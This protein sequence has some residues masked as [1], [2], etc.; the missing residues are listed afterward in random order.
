MNDASSARVELA[1]SVPVGTRNFDSQE[2]RTRALLNFS[3][4]RKMTDFDGDFKAIRL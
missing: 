4:R 1:F 3:T 2:R